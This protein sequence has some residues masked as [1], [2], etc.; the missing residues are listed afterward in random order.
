MNGSLYAK[1]L[2]KADHCSNPRQKFQDNHAI[3]PALYVSK[4]F[5]LNYSV[6]RSL[7]DVI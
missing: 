2:P 7:S 6:E 1:L 3:T 4:N 5:L